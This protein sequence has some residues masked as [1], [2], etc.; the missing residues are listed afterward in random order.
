MSIILR[1]TL[2]IMAMAC[3]SSVFGSDTQPPKPMI[4]GA[5]ID[6]IVIEN[7]NIYDT[8]EPRYSSFLFRLANK[9]H[10]RTSPKVIQRELLFETGEP[11]SAVLSEETARN[12]RQN[13]A[14]YDAWIE[15]ERLPN[16]HLLVRVMTIDQWSLSAG[17]DFSR[18]AG[19]TYWRL[20]STERNL[21]GRNLLLR[22][23]Y[24]FESV[25]QDHLRLSFSDRRFLGTRQK[26]VLDYSDN[27]IGSHQL[28]ALSHPFYD[29]GQSLSWSLSFAKTRG[30]CES[31]SN[32]TLLTQSM[33][34]SDL[35]SVGGALRLGDRSRYV[36]AAVQYDY[37]YQTISSDTILTQDSQ[38]TSLA[39]SGLPVDSSA[40]LFRV[41][42]A[43]HRVKFVRLNRIDG[44]GYVEDFTL[45][46][47]CGVEL[48]R[49]VDRDGTLYN[50]VAVG[51][52]HQ[53]YFHQTLMALVIEGRD[54]LDGTQV[55]RRKLF[56]GGRIYK[57][58]WSFATL[59]GR[60][61]FDYDRIDRTIEKLSLNGN[62]GGIRG[63]SKYFTTGDR[64]V[65][66]NL[67]C[68]FYTGLELLS[69][70]LGGVVFTDVGR[71]WRKDEQL[72]LRGLYASAGIG[73]RISLEKA[74]KSAMIRVDLSYSEP[75][76]WQITVGSAQ[77]FRALIDLS[78]LTSN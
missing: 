24:T 19:E 15:T 76:G 22:A 45:G 10:W 7:R 50:V 48:G 23:K 62:E 40:H 51:A 30:R 70:Q 43:I 60:L 73:L 65:V 25:E 58:I 12:L 75:S 71:T 69:A 14:L 37:L 9:F 53:V 36:I 16:G 32:S 18:T 49:A 44:F 67:E 8:S 33:V 31:Y 11:Y 17:L 20:G 61:R 26:V 72:G 66:A 54:W 74:S 56:A 52:T 28:V 57:H 4:E 77:F 35:A 34:K 59:A 64:R 63:L 1:L 5:I 29:L 3:S 39:Q 46:P 47:M 38:L 6:T 2:A 27:P 41:A 78:L 21:F 42:A 55:L 68:R 13:L